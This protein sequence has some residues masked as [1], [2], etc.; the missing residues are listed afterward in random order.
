MGLLQIPT[1]FFLDQ[2][3]AVSS[4]FVSVS[5]LLFR[6]TVPDVFNRM[7]YLKTF[8]GVADYGQFGS[9][10]GIIAGSYLSQR[11]SGVVIVHDTTLSA[12]RQFLGGLL[13]CI[14]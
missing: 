5:G 2:N 10:I 6:F 12:F 13:V 8:Y 3:I 11:L 9:G 4:T 1:Y 14:P 7:P